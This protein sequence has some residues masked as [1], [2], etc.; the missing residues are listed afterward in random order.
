MLD[1]AGVLDGRTAPLE[2]LRR[3]AAALAPGAVRARAALARAAG[4]VARAEASARELSGAGAA[5]THAARL[6]A[7]LDASGLRRR[8]GHAPPEVA[9]A[10][11]AALARLEEAAEAVARA[12][13][14]CGRGG[15]ALTAGAFAA[16]LGTA[17][18]A[19]SAAAPPGPAAG[20]V[21]LWSLEEAAG[22]SARGVVLAGCGRGW[23]PPPPAE[24]VLRDPERTAIARTVHRA[25]LPLASGRRAEGLHRVFAAIA[26]A[27]EAV[28][29][30]WGAP[31]PS[32][33]SGRGGPV[34]PLVADALRAVGA[35][36]PRGP[37][38]PPSPGA[39]RTAREALRAV[40]RA[41]SP[42]ALAATPLAER[43]GRAL[44]RGAVEAARR[45][46]GGPHAGALGGPP[47]A[48]LQAS[49]PQSWSPSQLERY[50]ECPFRLFLGKH[51]RLPDETPPDL[52]AAA[53]DEGT[54][55][56]R[57][58]ELFVRV[59]M[60]QGSWPPRGTAADLAGLRA[61]ADAA[62]LGLEGEGRAGDPAVWAGRR[63]VLVARLERFVLAEA[64]R[65][66][67][68]APVAVELR[69]GGKAPVPPLAVESGGQ[70]VLLEGRI[71]RVDAS[72]GRLR[73]VD[74]KSGR[75]DGGEHDDLLEP[76]SWGGRSFQVPIYLLAAA[77][78]FPGREE[79]EARYAFLRT[80]DLKERSYPAPGGKLG[81][82]DGFARE[83]VALVAR[84]RRGEFAQAPGG[85]ERCPWPAVCRPERAA[86]GEGQ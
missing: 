71:D 43:A 40:A 69:F 48:V 22:L 26:A 33:A 63:E 73:V 50:A 21:E 60:E 46:G 18:D 68:L 64:E 19:A 4:A 13:G 52:D 85:C 35:P 16:L 65:S 70:T 28:T 67:P 8:A 59:R 30:T 2:A 82:A 83:V 55:L 39:S 36:L 34:S 79:L 20:A 10:D 42:A 7:F 84:I 80:A 58:L 51:V 27:R 17:V 53:R 77:R 44:D 56:H 41:G 14:L 78:A 25:I 74:Y 11:L 72:P 47:L 62:L 54:L 86:A 31:G 45:A 6:S 24:A 37:E 15:E 9:A 66:G 76:E 57:A 32:G 23:P 81:G 1:A 5:R 3:R 49:L 38:A 75:S 29:F 61:A 12:V